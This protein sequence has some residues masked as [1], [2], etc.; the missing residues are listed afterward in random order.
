MGVGGS[1]GLESMLTRLR[2]QALIQHLAYAALAKIWQKRHLMPESLPEFL[3]Q[4][5]KRLA[6]GFYEQAH[7]TLINETA[8]VFATHPTAAQRIRKARQ[9]AEAGLFALEKPAR[10]LFGD[11]AAASKLV[12]GRHFRQNLR[13]AVT[14]AMLK[15]VS[16]F[17]P[18]A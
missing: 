12:T 14:P 9:R 5:E 3:D 13:L 18:G 6:A 4:F 7:L 8:G 15:P 17:F 10:A 2:E 16:A 11:F 1:A